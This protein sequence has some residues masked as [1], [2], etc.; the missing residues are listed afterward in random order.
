M[1]I[2]PLGLSTWGLP[3]DGSCAWAGNS[4]VGMA[5]GTWSYAWL[6]GEFWRQPQVRGM[7]RGQGGG[8]GREGG[9][10]GNKTGTVAL[11]P[12]PPPKPSVLVWRSLELFFP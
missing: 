1:L 4:V 8:G 11:R 5:M 6:A 12:M 9:G 7:G 3:A 2:Y 10:G